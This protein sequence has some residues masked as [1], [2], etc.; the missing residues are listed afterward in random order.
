MPRPHHWCTSCKPIP[1]GSSYPAKEYCSHCGLCDTY[2]I[3]HVKEACA[4]LEEGMGK[5]DTL[6]PLVQGR[7]RQ[8][9]RERR[10]GVHTEMVYAKMNPP[11]PGAQ[12][13]G[14]VTA[15]AIAMLRHNLVDGVV[16]VQSEPGDRFQPRPVIA[17]TVED[18]LQA[19]GVKPTLSPNL[20]ILECLEA[21]GL[22]RMLF[23]GVG[24]QVQA[25]RMVEPYLNLE[26]L[27]VL[28]IHCV[29]NGKRAGLDKFLKVA[30]RSPETVLHYEFMQDYQVHIQH[31][32]GRIET[33]PYFCLPA[34]Q[35]QDVIAP[36]CYSC[37]DYVNGLADLVV[38]YMGVPYESVPMTQHHQQV[39]IRN[40]KGQQMFDLIKPNLSV[41]PVTASGSCRPLVLQTVLQEEKSTTTLPRFM[42][43]ILARLLTQFGP[44]GLA[45]A[46]YSIDYHT[47]R[48]YLYVKRHWGK[49]GDRQIPGYA[50][51]IVDD[52][53]QNGQITE[54]L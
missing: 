35:L 34:Q 43:K 41:Q 22:K 36:S 44:K 28:G 11:I 53:N 37:F 2:Y 21:S 54:L 23:C 25:L 9:D 33:I 24:C 6:E 52:Y 50:Q 42:G 27:Y 12:W 20:N 47:I 45:F 30:S 5:M 13:T 38:G 3:A 7:G 49:Q 14:V 17:T 31:L 15:L 32:D 8:G 40:A 48:N 4:F 26:E 19:R 10:F 1:P 29:D 39:T 18:I 51:A 46:Q 16:C